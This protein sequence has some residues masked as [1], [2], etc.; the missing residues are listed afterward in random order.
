[1]LALLYKTPPAWA[2]VVCGDFD[3]FLQDHAANERKA[4]AQAIRL[5]VHHHDQPLLVDAMV[6]LAQEELEHFRRVYEVLRQRG[7]GLG[8]DAPDPYMTKLHELMRKA[9][10]A[11]FLLDRL[12]VFALVEA[13]GC[14]RFAMLAEVLEKGPLKQLYL[15]LTRAEA[16]HQGLFARIARE[17]FAPADV[18]ARFDELVT[19]EAEIV[20]ALPLR[21]A[22]H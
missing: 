10:A 11:D 16:R 18:E 8:Q 17:L 7:C 9:T 19:R 22:L 5:A 1:M 21:A 6:A 20:A 3:S 15:E 13:R 4:S 2:D 14:E 12:I